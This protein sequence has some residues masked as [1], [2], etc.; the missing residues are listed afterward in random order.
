MKENN[1][2][3]N[4]KITFILFGLVIII[5][6]TWAGSTRAATWTQKSDMPTERKAVHTEV[7][8]GKIYAIGALQGTGKLNRVEQYDPQTDIWTRKADMPTQRTF[9]GTSVVNGK[10]YVLG[11]S[12]GSPFWTGTAIATVEVY[13]PASDTWTP[14]ADMPMPREVVT[15][16]VN[17]K[18]YAIGGWRNGGVLATVEEYDPVTDTWTRK[19]DMPTARELHT[20][21]VINGKIY[22]IGGQ[23][24]SVLSVVEMYDPITD[25]WVRKADMPERR[26]VSGSC[27]LDEAI[28][29]FGGSTARG[30]SPRSNVF[31]YDSDTDTWTELEPMPILNAGIGVSTVGRRIY[32]I[33]GSSDNFP[34]TSMLSTVW[35][36]VPMLEFDFNEDSVVDA[37][38]MALMVDHWH[39]DAP[40]YD[41]APSPA[42]DGIV[43]VQDLVALSEHLFEDERLLAQWKLDETEGDVAYDSAGGNFGTLSG[44]PIW[45]PDSGQVAGALQFDGLDDYIST[46]KVLNPKFA[47]FSVF[48]WIK[49]GSPGQ[50]IISQ[51]NSFGGVG[52]TWLGIDPVNGCLMTELVSPPIGRFIAEPLESNF[53]ITDDI[54][55]HVGFVW[56]G[57]YRTLYVDGIE[58][59]KDTNIL[60]SLEN[61]DGGL[62]IG[63]NKSRNAGTFFSGLI[64][65]VRIYNTALSAE[66][67][68]ELV[69]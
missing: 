34:Y 16:A 37:L 4:I 9:L 25:T 26:T 7:V 45:Q 44:N 53:I 33:G 22:V 66:E 59:A 69:Q 54:W 19:A 51:K 65:D 42:G 57:S 18:I 63:V 12:I 60:T 29:V 23:S 38:D 50:V 55:H 15:C 47:E 40:R 41:L 20:T 30:G 21:N 3:K 13:D 27:V 11:G 61:S 35:E 1:K 2:Y 17:G 10:I 52:A 28:Y 6:M 32:L 5:V 31:R 58:V 24:Q 68:A 43:D 36:Y 46:D 49:G 56:D 67:I 8:D 48:A 14:R 64:D 39:T 62:Y